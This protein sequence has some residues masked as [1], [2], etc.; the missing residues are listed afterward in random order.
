MSDD[1]KP[2]ASEKAVAEQVGET[3]E[4]QIERAVADARSHPASDAA[5]AAMQ[6]P[7]EHAGAADTSAADDPAGENPDEMAGD[8]GVSSGA[9]TTDHPQPH[10]A[11]D[12][13]PGRHDA[14]DPANEDL[15][16]PENY[17]N[18]MWD[19]PMRLEETQ[20]DPIEDEKTRRENIKPD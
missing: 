14:P 15:D 7:S 11:K 10:G 2:V 1:D 12:V 18:R 17:R 16:S 9:T 4:D 5:R 13:S 3:T 20:P 19:G 6:D 8:I